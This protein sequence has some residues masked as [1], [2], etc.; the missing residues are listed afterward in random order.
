MFTENR[1]HRPPQPGPVI[2]ALVSNGVEYFHTVGF[3]RWQPVWLDD[4]TKPVN[5]VD[6]VTGHLGEPADIR[7]QNEKFSSV[8]AVQRRALVDGGVQVHFNL[9]YAAMVNSSPTNANRN[10]SKNNHSMECSL[11]FM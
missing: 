3:Q 1:A 7:W 8:M 4:P 11:R 9:R 2:P 5:C 10:V 6:R